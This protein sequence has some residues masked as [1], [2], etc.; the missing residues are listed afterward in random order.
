MILLPIK[1]RIELTALPWRRALMI[2]G[3]RTIVLRVRGG[4]LRNDVV[5]EKGPR[6]SGRNS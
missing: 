2:Q 4:S 1:V 3:G 5:T 6:M